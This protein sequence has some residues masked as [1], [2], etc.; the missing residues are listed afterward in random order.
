MT[1]ALGTNPKTVTNYIKVGQPTSGNYT[2]SFTGI[3]P[4]NGWLITNPDAGL[5]WEKRSNVGNG[6][7]A[8]MIMNNSD[9]S[10]LNEIRLYT[11]A[12]L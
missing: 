1:N 10:V 8:C 3:F 12:L 11:V 7:T 2:E 9:N 6:D 5:A 4:P